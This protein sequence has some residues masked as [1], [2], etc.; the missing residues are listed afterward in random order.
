MTDS[1]SPPPVSS[2]QSGGIEVDAQQVS[3]GGDVVGRDKVVQT[4]YNYYGPPPTAT[5]AQAAQVFISYKRHTAA[6]EPL[7]VQLHATLNQR[8]HHAFIDQAMRIGV[9]WA[10]EIQRQ[11]EGA[12]YFIVLLSPDS[13]HSEMVAKEI[14]FAYRHQTVHGRPVI[15]PVRVAF[16]S[17]LPYQL[18]LYLDRLQYALWRDVTD[19]EAVITALVN[20]IENAQAL[21]SIGATPIASAGTTEI[22]DDGSAHD[23]ERINH[24]PL[25]SFD[26]RTILETPS[27]AV[28]LKSQLYIARDCDEQVR[29]QVLGTGT[30]TTIRAPRQMGKTS[31]LVRGVQEARK[32]GR[33]VVYL[34]LQK[35]AENYLASLDGVLRYMADEIALRLNLEAA[36]VDRVWTSSR[37]PQDKLN[38]FFERTVLPAAEGP[39]LLA[40]DEADR[41]LDRA[42]K[43]DFFGLVRAWDSNRAYDELWEKLN[44]ALVIST[45]PHLLITDVSQSPFN[46]GLRL[47]LSDFNSA[48]V[49]ELNQRHGGPLAERDLPKFVE[50]FG[51][52]PYLTRQALYTLVDE[53]QSWPDLAKAAPSDDGPFG[54][55]LRSYLW[56]LSERPELV[57]GFLEVLARERCTDD[58][59][60][61]RLSAAGLVRELGERVVPRC[62]LYAQYFGAKLR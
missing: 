6:D 52:H 58:A 35:V 5:G 42:Y 14:D 21:P 31:L 62:S 54:S 2:T 18:S 45:H 40:I 50:L 7:A 53:Q 38:A 56:Q 33:A 59:V 48:Q 24:A 41:L 51:G 25:P 10:Q 4:V 29:R 32:A 26:P 49:A 47:Q 16:T 44:I 11:V 60:L 46:V 9:D 15:L 8:G 13:A 36:A 34:D 20:T 61:Y 57:S 43:T 30:T 27:G 55:Q 22:S 17:P 23:V 39:I 37:G 28:K 1:Q 12:D 19:T 3:V